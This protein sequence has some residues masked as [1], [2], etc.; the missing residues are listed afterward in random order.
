VANI[1]GEGLRDDHGW[2]LSGVGEVLGDPG[3][4]EVAWFTVWQAAASTLLTLVIALPATHVLSTYELPGRRLLQALL[5]V[6]FVLPTVVVGAAFLSLLGARGLLGVDLRGSAIAIIVAHS[7]FN[8]A[9]VVRTVGSLWEG[10]DPTTEEAARMLGASRWRAFAAVTWPAIRPA[11]ASAAAI[12]FLFSFTSFGVIRILGGPGRTTIETEI[13]R[14]TA[15]LLDLPVAS[16]L[17]LLQLA[18]VVAMLVVHAWLDRRQQRRAVGLRHPARR[19][20]RTLADRAWVATNLALMAVWLGV[21]IAVLIS[22]SFRVGD[23]YGLAGW[24][25]LVHSS[26]SRSI[27]S[28]LDA[29]GNSLRFAA[30]ATLLAVVL[31]GLAAAALARPGGRVLRSIDTLLLLPL[32]ISAVTVGFGFLLAMDE[33]VDLRAHPLLVPI[34]QA[35]VAIPF[36]IRTMTPVLRSIDPAL[37]EAAAVLGAAPRRAWMAVDLP[38]VWR[39]VLVAA[40]FAFAISMGEFGATVVIA[41]ADAPTIPITIARLLGRPGVVNVA[42]AYSLCVVLMV[43]TTLSVLLVDRWR[44]RARAGGWL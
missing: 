10:L 19:P 4:R 18:A 20:I 12:V 40:G 24:R 21:P 11:V 9:V 31:G 15:D 41:R 16:V 32:G 35:V 33:P 2:D 25:A 6:P 44:P 8:H 5:V 36:V 3:I 34:A 29:V 28:P 7:F 26:G 17:A 1:I 42:Q 23:G 30:I 43:V 13:Y 39:A 14:Q 22:R 37:R 27:V 38:L